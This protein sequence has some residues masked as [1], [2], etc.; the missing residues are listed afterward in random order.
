MWS[1][2]INAVCIPMYAMAFS[3][4]GEMSTRLLCVFL[5]YM[6]GTVMALGQDIPVIVVLL[7]ATQHIE[8]NEQQSIVM[9]K[10]SVLVVCLFAMAYGT[11]N[12]CRFY[13]QHK[14]TNSWTFSR[15]DTA[16]VYQSFQMIVHMLAMIATLVYE[17]M[18]TQRFTNLAYN[19]VLVKRMKQQ[20]KR[21]EYAKPVL[22]GQTI[23]KRR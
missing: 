7:L 5:I 10:L 11:W 2:A 6:L 12:V 9:H 16:L 14:N 4:V 8:G 22:S 23:S 15:A 3:I 20:V 19:P 1:I 17:S 21:L 13:Y 18:A